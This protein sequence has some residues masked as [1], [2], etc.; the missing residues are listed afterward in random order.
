MLATMTSINLAD[1]TV[2]LG[3]WARRTPDATFEFTRAVREWLAQNLVGEFA[4]LKGRGGPGSEH[5]F[6][7]ERL[8]WDRHLAASGW[9]CLGWP[10]RYGGRGATLEQRIIF[11]QEYALS[12][13]HI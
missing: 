9:T 5:E 8:A 3:E 11:H 7:A 1:R 13:I 12:L 6:F 4:L 10:T 2:D